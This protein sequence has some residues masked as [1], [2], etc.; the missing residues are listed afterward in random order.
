M[1]TECGIEE[2]K[3]LRASPSQAVVVS[4]D[5]RGRMRCMPLDG[6]I[7]DA[8]MKAQNERWNAQVEV[9]PAASTVDNRN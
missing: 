8:A 5:S 6:D 1:A 4:S 9:D 3:V 7:A 2:R